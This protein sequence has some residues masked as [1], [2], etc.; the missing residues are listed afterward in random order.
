MGL[1]G[2]HLCRIGDEKCTELVD[3][4]RVPIHVLHMEQDGGDPWY[5]KEHVNSP[6][7]SIDLRY[8]LLTWSYFCS[9]S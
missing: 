8:K 3:Y 7:I 5:G 6:D 4:L 1:Q 2:G 9:C